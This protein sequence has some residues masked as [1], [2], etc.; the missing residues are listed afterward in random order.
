[1]LYLKSAFGSLYFQTERRLC[2]FEIECC[3]RTR[4]FGRE[5]GLCAPYR[6]SANPL[7]DASEDYKV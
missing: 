2:E 7:E 1:M 3:G 5:L 6:F 4:P